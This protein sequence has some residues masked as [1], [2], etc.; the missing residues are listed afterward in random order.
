MLDGASLENGLVLLLALSCICQLCLAYPGC[1]DKSQVVSQ[2]LTLLLLS[3]LCSCVPR[4]PASAFPSSRPHPRPDSSLLLCSLLLPCVF[5]AQFALCCSLGL[6][7]SHAPLLFWLSACCSVLALLSLFASPSLS[8]VRRPL[9]AVLVPVLCLLPSLLPSLSVHPLQAALTGACLVAFVLL[10]SAC[11]SEL[12]QCFTPAELIVICSLLSLLVTHFSLSFALRLMMAAG[13]RDGDAQRWLALLPSS[14]TLLL[15]ETAVMAG[16]VL[17]VLPPFFFSS[18]YL[19]VSPSASRRLSLPAMAVSCPL[20][21]LGLHGLLALLLDSEPLSFLLRFMLDQPSVSAAPLPLQQ[22]LSRLTSHPRLLLA[23]YWLLC[24]AVLLPLS[25]R[26][27]S[28]RLPKTVMRKYYHLLALLLFLPSTLLDAAFTSVAVAAAFAL[29]LLLEYCRLQQM[30]PLSSAISAFVLPYLDARDA[31]A[32]ILTHSY[33][34]TGC[35]LPAALHCCLLST[36]SS[37]SS[38]LPV[39][40]ALA[41]VYVLG[42]GDA[43]ASVVGVYAGRTRWEGKKGKGGRTVEGTA[44]GV[45]SMLLLHVTVVWA[46]G[47]QREMGGVGGWLSWCAATVCVGLLEAWTTQIDNL[48]LPLF[49]YAAWLLACSP[50]FSTAR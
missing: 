43:M 36:Y 1:P 7:D 31:G 28:S 3:A 35:A 11:S 6:R 24:L 49:Y 12:S 48:M 45:L 14:P 20:L 37:S 18:S 21:L 44:G 39:L 26:P 46:V 32:V 42:A 40:P 8:L 38:S 19:P 34:L 29:F 41:G 13:L 16:L 25:P 33:L 50:S 15:A 10:V 47:L 30:T 2:S 4:R 5:S 17:S 23:C 9:T 22:R 27:S